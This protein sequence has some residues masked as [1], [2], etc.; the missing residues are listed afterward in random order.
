MADSVP[1]EIGDR[2]GQ[3]GA[4]DDDQV[5]ADHGI[6]HRQRAGVPRRAVLFFATSLLPPIYLILLCTNALMLGTYIAVAGHWD[7]AGAI[8]SILWCHGVLEIQAIVLAG[9]A[10]LCLVRAWVRPGPWSRKSTG[11]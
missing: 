8:S 11:T 2:S 10:G 5:Y 4:V 1:E 6:S 3:T 9:T 7:Q